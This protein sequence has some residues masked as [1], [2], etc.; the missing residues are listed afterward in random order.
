MSGQRIF[1]FFLV[2][3]QQFPI[4]RYYLK[5][6]KNLLELRLHY[7]DLDNVHEYTLQSL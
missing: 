7:N 6:K 4:L 3:Y 1:L 2:M 5:Y